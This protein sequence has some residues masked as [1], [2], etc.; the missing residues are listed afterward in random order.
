[1]QRIRKRRAREIVD[2]LLEVVHA[3][4]NAAVLGDLHDFVDDRLA[5]VL[6]SEGQHDGARPVHFEVRRPVLVTERVTGDDDRLGP[7]RD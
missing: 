5:A 7:T 4:H 1:L 3:H 6:R 2:R